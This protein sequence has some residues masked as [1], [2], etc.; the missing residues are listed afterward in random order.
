M[1]FADSGTSMVVPWGKVLNFSVK[2]EGPGDK[3]EKGEDTVIG[4]VDIE[5]AGALVRSVIY[6]ALI[7]LHLLPTFWKQENNECSDGF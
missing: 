4:L 1:V 7:L 6:Y 5:C 3:D 2:L